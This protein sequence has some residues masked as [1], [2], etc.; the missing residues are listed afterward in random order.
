MRLPRGRAVLR[1]AR[2]TTDK[3]AN[4]LLRIYTVEERCL[5]CRFSRSAYKYTNLYGDPPSTL[6]AEHAGWISGNFR[7]RVCAI[8]AIHDNFSRLQFR[9]TIESMVD[10]KFIDPTWGFGPGYIRHIS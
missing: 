6:R 7:K 1:P 9:S 5:M 4:R 2:A 8:A 3:Y 10:G